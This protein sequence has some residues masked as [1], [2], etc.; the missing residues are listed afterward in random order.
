[1][2]NK[3]LG[4]VIN[5]EHISFIHSALDRDYFTLIN[6]TLNIKVLFGG[7]DPMSCAP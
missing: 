6:F 3:C 7:I 1:M 2:K 4:F 5:A